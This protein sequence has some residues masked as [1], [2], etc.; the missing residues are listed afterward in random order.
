V[1]GIRPD[2]NVPAYQKVR[3]QPQMPQGVT[4]AKTFKETPYGKLNVNWELKEKKMELNVGIPVGIDAGV[5][6]P[7]GVKSYRIDG[8][9]FDVS[10][11]Q[12]TVVEVGSGNHKIYYSL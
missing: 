3:I 7:S 4:W 11:K 5:V 2:E 8:Q 12:E 9:K 1:G 6:I 10:G